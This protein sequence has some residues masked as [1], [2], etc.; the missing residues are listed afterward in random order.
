[1]LLS[2]GA[3]PTAVGYDTYQV[4]LEKVVTLALEILQE[5]LM[6]QMGSMLEIFGELQE[7][8]L[9]APENLLKEGG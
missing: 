4:M 1:M 6:R 7:S 3:S 2:L 5:T 8:L 9:G